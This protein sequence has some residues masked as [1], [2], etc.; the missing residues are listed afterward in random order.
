MS[1]I[2]TLI[3]DRG[4]GSF[5]NSSDL[6]RVGQAVEWLA[7]RLFA[8]GY[9]I[10]VTPE[11]DWTENS[12]PTASQMTHYL[13]DLRKIRETL[14]QPPDTPTAPQSMD[15]LT[16]EKANDIETILSVTNL[17]IEW[18]VSNFLYTGELFAGEV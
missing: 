14:T 16:Y 6:N 12:I 13:D 10:K 15:G 17:L 1:I 18:M 2:D 11:T 5:Y 9:Q 7:D 3:T 4:A 8:L